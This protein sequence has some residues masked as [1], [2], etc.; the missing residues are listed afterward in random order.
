MRKA[1]I[2]PVLALSLVMLQ[3]PMAANGFDFDKGNAAV[4]IVIPTV[5]P[6]INGT[7]PERGPGAGQYLKRSRDPGKY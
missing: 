4:E 7:A 5:A 1:R 6:V 3:T 2:L